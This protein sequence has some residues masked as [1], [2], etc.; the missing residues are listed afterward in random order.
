[1]ASGGSFVQTNW[2]SRMSRWVVASFIATAS[3]VDLLLSSFVRGD[4]LDAAIQSILVPDIRAHIEVLAD[5][6]LEGR[7]AGSSG[8]R[9]AAAYVTKK[10]AEF[11]L[12][13]GGD[14]GTF[15]QNFQNGSYRNLL[16]VLEGSDPELKQ[17]YVL[18][19]AHYDHVGY[20]TS[21][22][23]RGPWGRI[24]NGADDNAS[25]VSGVLEIAQALTLLDPPPRR[26]VLFAFWDGEEKGILGS[27]HW[28]SQ[29]T[30]PLPAVTI[31]F[32]ADMIGRLRGETLH[33]FGTR[34]AV[35][36]RRWLSENNQLTDLRLDFSWELKAHSDH[37]PL[38]EHGIPALMLHT[39]L[40]DDWHRPSDDVDKIN[41]EGA[42][43]TTR[44]L[45]S[46]VVEA[47][48]QTSRFPFRGESRFENPEGLTQLEKPVSP[49]SPRLGIAW[50]R[51]DGDPPGVTLTNVTPG[52]TAD[53]AGLQAGDRLV[54][55]ANQEAS[56]ESQLGVAIWA[57]SSPATAVIEREGGQSLQILVELDG[58]PLRYGI[59]W[60]E[61]KGEPGTVLLT[62]VVPH[63]S[64]DLAGLQVGDRIYR[65]ADCEFRDAEEL[66]RRLASLPSPVSVQIERRG[67]LRTISID[68]P[69]VE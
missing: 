31:T 64:A 42:A 63:S 62:E 41:Y 50:Q 7:A 67:Q 65:V 1:M 51:K 37:F 34:T 28:V 48:N 44:L 38:V 11:G 2:E 69:S 26:S 68:A 40:H 47:A 52:S 27:K 18:V 39:G 56:N 35:G 66:A 6:A 20:G 49:R 4:E 29:P 61:D 19:G 16:A 60:R 57:A 12:K 23:S 8:S 32:N 10:L 46:L 53:R 15:A 58:Q 13:S 59:S 54:R 9:T 55:F 17:E 25:G 24:H 21:R 22:N 33:V 30:V 36:M 43:A 45:F 14:R 3:C 5:D